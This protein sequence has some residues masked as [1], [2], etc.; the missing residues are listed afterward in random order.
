MMESTSQKVYTRA[1]RGWC[2]RVQEPRDSQLNNHGNSVKQAG[3]HRRSD[4]Y[5]VVERRLGHLRERVHDLSDASRAGLASD[6]SEILGEVVMGVLRLGSIRVDISVPTTFICD[7]TSSTGPDDQHND[8]QG[9]D[10][11]RHLLPGYGRLDPKSVILSSFVRIVTVGLCSSK[12]WPQQGTCD[13]LDQ[14]CSYKC[15]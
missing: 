13:A 11:G 7:L 2:I 1:P 15:I 6:T 10:I 4:K 3:V 14:I 9:W 8:Q 12:D 5:R